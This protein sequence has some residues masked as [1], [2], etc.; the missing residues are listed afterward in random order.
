MRAV[1]QRVSKAKV[2]ANQTHVEQI[3]TGLVVLLGIT[4]SDLPDD[5]DWLVQKIINMRI[6]NDDNGV[7]NKSLLNVDGEL[8]VVSQFTLFAKT[9][10]GNRPSYSNAAHHEIAIPLYESFIEKATLVLGKPVQCG[11]FGAEMQIGL[12]NDG[13]VTI[14]M[15]SKNKDI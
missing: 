2:T 1:I 7:M 14:V 15:D 5:V 8:M 3:G 4:H 13:P 12:V 6:F 10:K 11:I 9:K